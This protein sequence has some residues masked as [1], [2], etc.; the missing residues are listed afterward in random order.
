MRKITEEAVNNFYNKRNWKKKNTEIA[1]LDNV[2]LMELHRNK[3]AQLEDDVLSITNAGWDTKTTRE[4]LNG[5]DNGEFKVRINKYN[6]LCYLNNEPWDGKWKQ[7][8][9]E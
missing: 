2:V 1:V 8:F 3:I 6:G 5:L 9:P 4:R 7:I